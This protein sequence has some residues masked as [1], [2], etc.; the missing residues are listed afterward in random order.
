MTESS[1]QQRQADTDLLREMYD[2]NHQAQTNDS[3]EI[4]N[5]LDEIKREAVKRNLL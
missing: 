4:Q 1:E 3:P 5:R 2:L